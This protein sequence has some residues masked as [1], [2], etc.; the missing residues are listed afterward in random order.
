MVQLDAAAASLGGGNLAQPAVLVS[1][2]WGCQDIMGLQGLWGVQ[3]SCYNDVSQ[4]DTFG[5]EMNQFW[6]TFD[7]LGSLSLQAG[8]QHNHPDQGAVHLPVC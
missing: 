4:L 2:D 6:D 1:M 5:M 8:R 7:L 3:S